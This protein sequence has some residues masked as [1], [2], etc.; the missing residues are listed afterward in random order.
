MTARRP[1]HGHDPSI[2]LNLRKAAFPAA[3][4]AG[5]GASFLLS[6]SYFSTSAEAGGP[7]RKEMRRPFPRGSVKFLDIAPPRKHVRRT[8][9]RPPFLKNSAGGSPPRA[10]RKVRRTH[11]FHRGWETLSQRRPRKKIPPLP[12]RL[13]KF[14]ASRGVSGGSAEHLGNRSIAKN[15]RQNISP[16]PAHPPRKHFAPAGNARPQKRLCRAAPPL[17]SRQW[18]KRLEICQKMV[19]APPRAL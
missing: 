4:I 2:C 11:P 19:L 16:P 7:R 12:P 14:A 17:R 3:A 1:D 9:S 10:V 8:I 15:F 13:E 18:R 6:S 5:P